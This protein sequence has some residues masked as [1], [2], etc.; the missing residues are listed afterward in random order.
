[1]PKAIAAS[2]HKR[3]HNPLEDDILATGILKN[4][5]GRPSKRANKKVAEE[6]N[7]VDS[8]A[9]RKILAMS[10][11]LMDEEEQQLKNKQVTVASTAFDFD[12]SRMDH[13][14]DDQEE[15]V[16]NEEWGDEDEDA[17]DNDNEVDAADLEIFNRFVQPT[18]KDDP[19]L[20]H[21]WD[22]KPADG[23]E[24][25]E[26]QTNLADLILQKIAEKEAMTGGQNG[27][28]PIEEDY[29]I[30]PKVVEVFTK[31][32]LI[33]ARYKSGPLPKPFKV[34]PTIPHWE[35]II[36]LTRP[37]LWTPNACYAATRIFVSAKP[38]VVQRF[39]EMII[40][41][42]V[43]E[44]IHENKKLNVHLFNCLKKALYKPAGF[45]KGFLFPLAASGTCTLREAQIISAVLA[46]ISIPVLHSAAAIKTLCDIAAEQASQRAEC[47]SATNYLLKVLL[48]KRYA[49]PWQ[50]IDALVF[51][52]LRYASM[53]REGDGA[54][55]AL[56]VIFHQCLLVFAQRYRNDITEDQREALLDLLLTHG[57]EKIAPEIRKELLAGRGRGIPV[58]QPQPTFDGDDTMLV[59]S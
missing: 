7:Y 52:F 21:G 14:E 15:F 27:G 19:L 26:E 8:K 11:E 48:E 22:Q 58:Q 24:E 57:H 56:P 17:G 1:M 45:F 55:K 49:L 33:L 50:C 34:L 20:T 41:E 53:A 3:R 39:M 6:E 10:R 29:E 4:R 44:D 16:N 36:Q 37:D 47:V 43:R 59:D 28:N 40:L 9:S 2:S 18:M 38:Q 12:P 25:K 30:P 51:H 35:D 32:G 23:E 13:D 31:I 5:E 54:P 42:R 46:R